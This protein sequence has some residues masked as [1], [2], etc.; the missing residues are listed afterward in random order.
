MNQQKSICVKHVDVVFFCIS[1]DFLNLKWCKGDV[2]WKEFGMRMDVYEV[3]YC[4]IAK[5][6]EEKKGRNSGHF[7]KLRTCWWNMHSICILLKEINCKSPWLN[8]KCLEDQEK[9]RK[10][11]SD[12]GNSYSFP[13]VFYPFLS[14]WRGAQAHCYEKISIQWDI[15]TQTFTAATGNFRNLC[16]YFIQTG[17]VTL[18]VCLRLHFMFLYC[19]WLTIS[20]QEPCF[21][22]FYASPSSRACFSSG[23][24]A[25]PYSPLRAPSIRSEICWRAR[26]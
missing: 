24:P 14:F 19:T 15:H 18:Q 17:L 11:T 6:L 3:L 7:L 13:P 2:N 26:S 23:R 25:L 12:P 9:N 20:S 4:C 5:S 8:R 16:E 21:T 10:E 1:H 22:I